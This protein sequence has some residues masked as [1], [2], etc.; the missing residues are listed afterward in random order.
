MKLYINGQVVN[1]TNKDELIAA[2][3]SI[4]I[5]HDEPRYSVIL[6]DR[7]LWGVVDT[8]KGTVIEEWNAERDA[9]LSCGGRNEE[10]RRK[11]ENL[12]AIKRQGLAW[13]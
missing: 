13:D 9:R 1:V 3:K 7:S 12:A 2:T 5:Q 4:V 6:T 11:N 10:L 8:H